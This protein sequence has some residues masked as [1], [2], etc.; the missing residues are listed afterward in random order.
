MEG[1]ISIL[2]AVLGLVVYFVSNNAKVAE[3]GRI[4]YAMGLL[5]FLLQI[6]QA[7]V[8]LFR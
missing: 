8:S 5:A 3:A 7:T 1:Y 4:A 6:G 2:I